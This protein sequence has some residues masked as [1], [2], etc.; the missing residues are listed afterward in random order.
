MFL[1][2]GRKHFNNR[3]SLKSWWPKWNKL[4]Y[5]S[6]NSHFHTIL[7]RIGQIKSFNRSLTIQTIDSIKNFHLVWLINI[8]FMWLLFIDHLPLF[9]DFDLIVFYGSSKI[10]LSKKKSFKNFFFGFCRLVWNF[11]FIHILCSSKRITNGD[12]WKKFVEKFGGSFFDAFSTQRMFEIT[13]QS[14]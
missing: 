7:E 12:I 4:D 10:Q 14:V 8:R 13:T 6:F 9:Y 1:L 3:L 11:A 2:W 5:S